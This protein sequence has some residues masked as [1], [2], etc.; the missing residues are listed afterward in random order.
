LRSYG[1]ELDDKKRPASWCF[2]NKKE[3]FIND[4]EKEHQ[5][6]ISDIPEATEGE[7]PESIIYLPLVYKDKAI[8]VITAQS[9]SKNAYTE[10]HLNILRSLAT[11]T[12]LAL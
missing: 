11:Y 10:Y 5:L 1:Y 6:Y 8:G 12:A 3:I 9:F 7:N 2:N 4:F